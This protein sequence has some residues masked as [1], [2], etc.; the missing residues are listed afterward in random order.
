MNL[1]AAVAVMI[2]VTTAS[3]STA[4]PRVEEDG[5]DL[6][7]RYRALTKGLKAK[8]PSSLGRIVAPGNNPSV[9]L[10]VKELQMGL[11]GLLG[12][13]AKASKSQLS[14]GGLVVGTLGELGSDL[15]LNQNFGGL[16][17]EAFVVGPASYK[18]KAVTVITGRS[19]VAVLYGA[20]WLLRQIQTGSSLPTKLEIHSP[21][22]QH[23]LLNHWDNL[24]RS[25]ERGY[26]GQSIWDWHKL[27][28]YVDPKIKDYARANASIGINGSVLTN[29]NSN[30]NLLRPDFIAKAAAIADT[31]RPYG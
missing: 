23:R 6:W 11:S 8:Y 14:S 18:G 4:A 10:A 15:S 31:L 28:D 25:V 27:P 9:G 17:R 12:L 20:F 26:A 2:A 1:R 3:L 22:I 21:K 30:A 29:V 16:A 5:Y 19:G 7:L 13:D 24:N